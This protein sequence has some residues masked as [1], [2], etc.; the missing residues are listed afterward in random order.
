MRGPA[1]DAKKRQESA[2]DAKDAKEG[3]EGGPRIT[4][5]NANVSAQR[6]ETEY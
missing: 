5:T 1:N 2:K 4:Q 6:A 3:D